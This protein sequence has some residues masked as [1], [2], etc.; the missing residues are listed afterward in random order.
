MTE[1]VAQ[2]NMVDLPT[3]RFHYLS[4][5]AE[6]DDLPP[7][8][9]LH[10]VTSSA[11][12]WVRVGP[13]LAD[14]YRVYALDMRGHGDSVK[15]NAGTYTLRAVADDVLAFMQALNLQRPLLMGHSW[16]GATAIVLASGAESSVRP[17]A[18]A[19]VIL[20]DPAHNFS[21]FISEDRTISYTRDIGRPAQELRIEIAA[22]NP[23]WTSA[24]VE[25]KIDALQKVTREAVISVF[26]DGSQAGELL[27]R[28]TQ[29]HAPTLLIRAGRN[30]DT[31][32]DDKAWELAQQYLPPRSRAVELPGASHNIHR[33]RF[34][35]F[36]RVVDEFLHA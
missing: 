21:G 28:L 8:L 4:W 14:R 32:L 27:P 34:N 30:Q 1:S 15:S 31:T 22:T 13:A 7:A 25:G 10:G 18:L 2:S 23:G 24:D 5:N 19:Q 9:L 20:E 12:S 36:M 35:E 3:G 26:A 29:I 6:R 17:P 16:G 11:L 33:S